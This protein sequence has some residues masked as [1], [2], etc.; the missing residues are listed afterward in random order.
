MACQR[1][2]LA[3]R[4]CSVQQATGG[5]R[6]QRCSA[7]AAAAASQAIDAAAH[8]P[9]RT[10]RA[11][12]LAV[13]AGDACNDTVRGRRVRRAVRGWPAVGGAMQDRRRASCLL[14]GAASH[15]ARRAQAARPALCTPAPWSPHVALGRLLEEDVGCVW[16][17]HCEAGRGA[18]CGAKCRV[19]FAGWDPVGWVWC[20][21][22]LPHSAGAHCLA[23]CAPLPCSSPGAALSAPHP[24]SCSLAHPPQARAHL[25]TVVVPTRNIMLRNSV[26]TA[27]AY[28]R[29]LQWISSGKMYVCSHSGLRRAGG[30]AQ[31]A[32]GA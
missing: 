2:Q 6:A 25:C 21:P 13:D 24:P 18:P 28:S 22:A 4:G 10:R 14:P 15:P 9:A 7:A 30:R 29:S 17:R 23:A 26:A 32:L 3:G 1:C 16:R 20:R 8:P 27:R 5:G 19:G 31:W 12:A 11:L